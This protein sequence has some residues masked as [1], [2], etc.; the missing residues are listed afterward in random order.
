MVTWKRISGAGLVTLCLLSATFAMDMDTPDGCSPP[1]TSPVAAATEAVA[2]LA[3][4]A[5]RLTYM[6][7][8]F[9]GD[10]SGSMGSFGSSVR[11][12]CNGYLTDIRDA[13][14]AQPDAE[15]FVEFTVF[16]TVVE[17]P[18]QGA[19][20][21]LD[22]AAIAR[23]TAALAPRDLTRL[24]DTAAEAIRAQ[25]HRI[26]QHLVDGRLPESAKATLTLLTDGSDNKSK[27]TNEAQLKALVTEHREK[28][29]TCIFMAANMNA[30]TVG[31]RFGF[32]PTLCITLSSGYE[33]GRGGGEALRGA[34]SRVR[35]GGDAR[36]TDG[37][38]GAAMAVGDASASRGKGAGRNR[39]GYAAVAARPAPA[40]VPVWEVD[41]APMNGAPNWQPIQAVGSPLWAGPAIAGVPLGPPVN[42]EDISNTPQDTRPAFTT[43]FG[44]YYLREGGF[45][46][47]DCGYPAAAWHQ[48]AMDDADDGTSFE[49]GARMRQ[50]RRTLQA[51]Y[52]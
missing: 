40:P 22:D 51:R 24:Y 15:T 50:V 32:D 45:G 29:V 10:H 5:P 16:D 36:F 6:D 49:D 47:H 8:A 44:S 43:T 26:Q 34:M 4:D 2:G 14:P 42:L 3:I 25:A 21:G 12:A 39:A 31:D 11:E 27:E 19:A 30:Q 1:P 33:G 41:V 20:T 35:G 23:C 38:R 7:Y 17:T 9:C 18:F 13:I 46:R 28:G 52:A 48:I 37:E